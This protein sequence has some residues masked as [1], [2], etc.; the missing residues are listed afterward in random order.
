MIT[1]ELTP[2]IQEFL[3]TDPDKRD[4][5]A[6][7]ELLLRISPRNRI[8]HD[9]IV[10]NP[11]RNAKLLE[12]HLQKELKKRLIETTH[13]EVQSMMV[14]V[15]AI[16]EQRGFN[17]PER[18]EF[19]KGKRADH[20]E[21]PPEVQQLY[22]DNAD[23]MRRMRDAHTKLRMINSSNSTCP[24]S[25]RYPLAKAIIAY[26]KQ[27]RD[28][29]NVYDHYVKGTP[30]A[31]TAR[32]VDPRTAAKTRP[33]LSTCCSAN[34]PNSRRSLRLPASAS[35]TPLFLLHQNLSPVRCRRQNCYEALAADYI[36]APSSRRSA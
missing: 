8:L 19:Q 29:W 3:N 13:E 15:D 5:R 20:D 25:D 30:V 10:R 31:S 7:A 16:A 27:Y 35:F 32:A 24:D 34:M 11:A 22:V 21:L 4:I 6:G 14:Q 9:N 36:S 26:D 2:K 28:N 12:Y 1:L 18:S 23:I 33:R 17:R